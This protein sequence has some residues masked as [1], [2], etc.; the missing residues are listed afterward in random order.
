MTI[1]LFA[2]R[3]EAEVRVRQECRM[4]KNADGGRGGERE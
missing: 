1:E 3:S 2:T 4:E